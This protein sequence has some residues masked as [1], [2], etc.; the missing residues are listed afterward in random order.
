[1]SETT[2]SISVDLIH[3]ATPPLYNIIE[4]SDRASFG[5]VPPSNEAPTQ[6]IAEGPKLSLGRTIVV[7]AMLTGINAVSN[8]TSGLLVVALPR[9]AEDLR[10][11]DSLILW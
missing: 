3:D 11:A 7:I 1:M 9:M 4:A 8:M 10:L 5:N 6:Q 2:I